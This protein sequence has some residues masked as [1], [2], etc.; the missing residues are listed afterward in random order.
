M[1]AIPSMMFFSNISS[2]G[3]RD[4]SIVLEDTI[5]GVEVSLG[6]GECDDGDNGMAGAVVTNI[7]F[8][9]EYRE[10]QF[11]FDNIGSVLSTAMD[12]IG[13]VV[14]ENERRKLAKLIEDLLQSEVV[15][16]VCQLSRKS[17]MTQV[18]PYP[19][20]DRLDIKYFTIA[21]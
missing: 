21:V 11:E 3:V 17:E 10:I 4:F 16:I 1:T 12:V 15:S 6:I 19:H 20:Y 7:H 9:L 8:P 14:V 5:V 2:E 13:D 18:D